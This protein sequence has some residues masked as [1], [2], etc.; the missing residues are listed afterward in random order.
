MHN[1]K[2]ERVMKIPRVWR[3]I[4]LILPIIT[5]FVSAPAKE[6]NVSA[7]LPSEKN[8]TQ[9]QRQARLYRQQGFELQKTGIAENIDE[10]RKF[11]QK[12]IELDPSYAVAYNDL[13]V[14]YEATGLI[15]YAVQGY[16]MAIKMDPDYL[17]VY[18]N[19]AALY[20]NKGDLEKAYSFWKLRAERGLLN[21]PWT[22]KARKKALELTKS[23][24]ALREQFIRQQTEKLDKE[25]AEYKR[26]KKLQDLKE[27][28]AHSDYANKLY[29]KEE[30][31]Q[32]LDELKQ[33][34]KLNPYLDEA[35][36]LKPIVENRLAEQRKK[37]N[38]ARMQEYFDTGI[39]FY[40][41]DNPQLAEQ[42]F[43]KIAQACASPQ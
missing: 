28:Q 38:L 1:Q 12:A 29:K 20:E 24:P 16:Q 41:Q 21:D 25:I 31:A 11:Y 3:I 42:E 33:A 22:D 35:L 6:T 2:R 37:N 34:I 8:L 15:D 27:A 4:V 39:K 10:A 40:Q 43:K 14:I 23:I 26:L 17:S 36:R 9:L 18:S 30:Y 32:A 5:L 7:S 19:L 13:G